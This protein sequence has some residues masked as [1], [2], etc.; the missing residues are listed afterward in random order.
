[1][2]EKYP[3]VNE[4]IIRLCD[5]C[6][7][8][9]GKECHTPGCAMFLHAVDIPFHREILLNPKKHR[10]CQF[11]DQELNRLLVRLYEPT[12]VISAAMKEQICKV[13]DERDCLDH[14]NLP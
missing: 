13:L 6:I 7:D 10:W 5:A 3:Q 14:P 11:S 9:Q 1:V 4:Y 2:S 8:G 12:D